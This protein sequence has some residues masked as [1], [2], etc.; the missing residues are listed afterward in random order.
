[1]Y[2]EVI[3]Y[4]KNQTK[5][6]SLHVQTVIRRCAGF[7]YPYLPLDRFCV[8]WSQDQSTPPR[9]ANSQLV[10]LIWPG[11]VFVVYDETNFFPL[12]LNPFKIVYIF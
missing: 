6:F 4:F 11:T 1:M 5:S 8:W 12:P 7:N 3:W 10:V 9:L 2:L